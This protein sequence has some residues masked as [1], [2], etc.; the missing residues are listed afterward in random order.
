M[1]T[2]GRTMVLSKRMLALVHCT[3]AKIKLYGS[4]LKNVTVN[5]EVALRSRAN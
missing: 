3:S 5:M 1:G 4:A 2:F